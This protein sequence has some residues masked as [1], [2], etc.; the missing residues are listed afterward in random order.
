MYLCAVA[1]TGFAVE[2][3]A[4]VRPA[5]CAG[6]WYPGEPD[7]LTKEVDELLAKASPPRVAGKPIAIISPH[8][9]YRFSAPCAAAGYKCLQGHTYKRVILLAFSHRSAAAYTGVDVPGGLT[10]YKTPLGEVPIDGEVCDALL[11]ELLFA[12][13]PGIDRGEHSL[14]L[15]LPFLQRVLGGFRLVPLLVG[16]MS[17]SDCTAAARAIRPWLDDDTLLS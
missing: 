4:T 8:A 16:K 7:A 3:G 9:G 2:R 15:Q 6:S 10:A 12:S 1:G 14:E 5:Y 17:E 11:S 13:H